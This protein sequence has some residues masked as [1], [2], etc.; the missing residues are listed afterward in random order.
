[1]YVG[2]ECRVFVVGNADIA[3]FNDAIV[4]VSGDLRTSVKGAYRLKAAKVLIE[5]DASIDLKAGTELRMDAAQDTY[6]DMGVAQAS[7]LTTPDDR[8]PDVFAP[9]I[10]DF[11]GFTDDDEENPDRL[12]ELI[13]NGTIP[14]GDIQDMQEREATQQTKKVPAT[15]TICGLTLNDSANPDYN[16]RLTSNFTL[17]NLSK[18]ALVQKH[19]VIAQNGLSVPDIICNLKLLAVNSLDLIKA[20]YPT[21]QITSGFRQG[22]GT[23]QHKRGMAA[24]IQYSDLQGLSLSK[25]REEYYRRAQWIIDN[26]P[27]DQFLLEYKTYG[28]GKPWH[29]ISFNKDSLRHDVRTFNNDKSVGTGLRLLQA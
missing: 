13:D 24:D 22:S 4:N 16:L 8:A 26:V 7:G 9:T 20:K 18:Y 19:G 3:C 6:I 23:S 28:S 1:V 11:H 29:H 5:A 17:G 15:S 25:Q 27:F 2:G 21:M 10:G 12:Q 14:A